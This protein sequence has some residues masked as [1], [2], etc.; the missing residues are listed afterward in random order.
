MMYQFYPHEKLSLIAAREQEE[1]D[2]LDG[3]DREILKVL[4]GHYKQWS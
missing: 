2:C 3:A 4:V 1:I